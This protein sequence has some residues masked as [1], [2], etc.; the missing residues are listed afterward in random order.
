VIQ[1]LRSERYGVAREL[2]ARSDNVIAGIV[3]NGLEK[4][5][6]GCDE[7][8]EA[9]EL[10]ARQEVSGLWQALGYLT[11]VAA[12]APM[13]GLLG[14]VVGMIQA[15]N[16]IAFET[17]VVKPILLAGGVSKA[18]VTTAAG[19]VIAIVALIFHSYFRS[20]VLDI[21]GRVESL[22]S[23]ILTAFKNKKKNR[24]PAKAS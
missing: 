13:L 4:Q 8:T 15:F 12:I 6:Q 16:T 17:A 2:C 10:A 1:H 5:D 23:E 22:T 14:T 9:V 24:P 19:M 11:D 7:A 21:T 18:M 20:K 3:Q